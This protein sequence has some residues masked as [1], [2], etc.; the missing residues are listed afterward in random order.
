[1]V[2]F[3]KNATAGT[4]LYQTPEGNRSW[5]DIAGVRCIRTF[6]KINQVKGNETPF[7]IVEVRYIPC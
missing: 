7:N 6:L 5:F 3:Q 4:Q 1:M 2:Q